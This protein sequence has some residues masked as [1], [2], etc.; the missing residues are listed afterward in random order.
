[1]AASPVRKRARTGPSTP[2][3]HVDLFLAVVRLHLEHNLCTTSLPEDDILEALWV[4]MENLCTKWAVHVMARHAFLTR[5]GPGLVRSVRENMKRQHADVP[6][7]GACWVTGAAGRTLPVG[8]GR[9]VLAPA[10][11][12]ALEGV[13]D[14][15]MHQLVAS[16]ELRASIKAS[17]YGRARL[18]PLMRRLALASIPS[19]RVAGGADR[20][21]CGE[22]SFGRVRPA[23]V[24]LPAP[25]WDDSARRA[26]RGKAW[27]VKVLKGR[28]DP[29]VLL[30]EMLGLLALRHPHVVH[31]LGV[32]KLGQ[33]TCLVVEGAGPALDVFLDQ[34][35]QDRA[36]GSPVHVCKAGHQGT[37]PALWRAVQPKDNLGAL[38][39]HLLA[40]ILSALVYLHDEMGLIHGDIK[41]QNVC[42]MPERG[43]LV[44]LVDL[45]S[46]ELSRAH[47]DGVD[48]M[49][50]FAT[51][52][53][54]APEQELA[55]P[56][57]PPSDIWSAGCVYAQ[58]LAVL[59]GCG[60]SCMATVPCPGDSSQFDALEDVKPHGT[61][62]LRAT[63]R[64]ALRVQVA[65]AGA[66][67]AGLG[68]AAALLREQLRGV[69]VAPAPGA[70]D[71]ISRRCDAAYRPVER[72]ALET[73]LVAE[74]EEWAAREASTTHALRA[75]A[76]E[77]VAP[78]RLRRLAD[79]LHLVPHQRPR[80]ADLLHRGCAVAPG[81]AD[82]FARA[83]R[84]ARA[85]YPD[86]PLDDVCRALAAGMPAEEAWRARVWPL[87]SPR[88]TTFQ[89]CAVCEH[90]DTLKAHY[91]VHVS[92]GATCI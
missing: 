54:R 68:A 64:G 19:V 34:A 17:V 73:I 13:P 50:V 3:F 28:E 37:I 39:D 56:H 12:R 27:V 63:L 62:Q 69:D 83:E 58:L 15:T 22:G 7:P 1:M 33:A 81:A 55:Q 52:W 78:A 82:M 71:V 35:G 14:A 10:L 11:R 9:V 77:G 72:S 2:H 25:A 85:A 88:R 46:L 45:G 5:H 89:L 86:D 53:Y 66:G 8:G 21:Q 4:D 84:E 6:E 48:N 26:L 41:P 60:A 59:E 76:L 67:S 57:N 20:L 47:T 74:K 75:S 65:A 42:V 51:L 80:A 87:L 32:G 91:H 40:Q 44:R 92:H 61:P 30:R 43:F 70:A 79:M 23:T 90:V 16:L 24:T 49:G 36:S 31:G 18:R 38:A 29:E